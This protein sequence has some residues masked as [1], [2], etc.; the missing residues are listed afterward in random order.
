MP[1]TERSI[2]E[3]TKDMAFH[4]GDM[5]RNE[6]KLARVEATEGV[7]TL[8]GAVGV[9]AA[10]A[11]VGASALTLALFAVAYALSSVMPLWGAAAIVAVLAGILAWIMVKAGQKALKPEELTLTRTRE[12]VSRDIKSIS[13]HVH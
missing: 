9:I 12:Q 5:F 11:V 1:Q 3:L 13:E 2:P 8:S 7:K 6:L 10:G 4:L